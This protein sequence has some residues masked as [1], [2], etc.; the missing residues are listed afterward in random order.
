MPEM[1]HAGEDHRDFMFV[2]RLNNFLI[3]NRAARLNNR[4]N[5]GFRRD[6]NCIAEREKRITGED[7]TFDFQLG[8]ACFHDSNR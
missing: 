2:R 8:I 7:T 1:A 5:A 3:A 6:I 4:N